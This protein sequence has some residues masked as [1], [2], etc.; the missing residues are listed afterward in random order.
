MDYYDH[1][2]DIQ[3]IKIYPSLLVG[4]WSRIAFQTPEKQTSK[5]DDLSNGEDHKNITLNK[6]LFD[7]HV[8]G[9]FFKYNMDH[10]KSISIVSNGF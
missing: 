1:V 4:T 6:K 8:L 2:L 7:G 9:I 5:S 10:S 3:F